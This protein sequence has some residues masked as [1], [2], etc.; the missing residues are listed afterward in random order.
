MVY[1]Q[2]S[3]TEFPLPE[4]VPLFCFPFGVSVEHWDRHAS[5]PIP[6]FLTFA[7]TGA[8]GNCVRQ[9]RET[10]TERDRGRETDRE[11]ERERVCVYVCK[12]EDILRYSHFTDVWSLRCLL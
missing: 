10:D 4:S 3:H 7:L 1:K 5:F 9:K 11:K 2:C 12:R 6:T 8:T